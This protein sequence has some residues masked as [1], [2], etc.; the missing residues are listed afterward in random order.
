MTRDHASTLELSDQ[1]LDAVTGGG[2]QILNK[3]Q[4]RGK[5][6]GSNRHELGVKTKVPAPSGSGHVKGSSQGPIPEPEEMVVDG[7]QN[8]LDL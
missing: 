3:V 1:D 2:D 6:F 5:S 4:Q 7:A 8:P